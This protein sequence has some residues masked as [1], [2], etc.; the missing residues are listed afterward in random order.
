MRKAN[1]KLLA[2]ASVLDSV[3]KCLN[4]KP[5]Y[6]I[7]GLDLKGRAVYFDMYDGD[8]PG[9]FPFS[10]DS[11]ADYTA[12]H[13]SK[14]RAEKEFNAVRKELQYLFPN[15]DSPAWRNM[16]STTIDTVRIIQI[17]MQVSEVL[18][19]V[20]RRKP[21]SKALRPGEKADDIF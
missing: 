15:V 10:A 11:V 8:R 14:A 20:R 17:G 19:R 21:V 3:Q 12:A 16:D 4:M 2:T 6:M 7:V 1:A 5:R 9:P 13:S 18:P